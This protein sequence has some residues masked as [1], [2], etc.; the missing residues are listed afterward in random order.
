MSTRPPVLTHHR[1]PT[2]GF[3]ITAAIKT[4]TPK[5]KQLAACLHPVAAFSLATT[6]LA[7]YEDSGKPPPCARRTG[8][9]RQALTQCEVGW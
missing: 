7:D 5:S 6:A 9:T 8:M 4:T 2:A 1:L 3:F